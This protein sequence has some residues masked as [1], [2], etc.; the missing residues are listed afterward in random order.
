M[1][2][3]SLAVAAIF[4]M[5]VGLCGAEDVKKAAPVAKAA[6]AVK[7]KSDKGMASAKAAEDTDAEEMESSGVNRENLMPPG[8]TYDTNT[9]MP[10]TVESD[11]NGEIE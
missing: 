1:R 3:L 11:T 8:Q 4:M 10:N 9:G 6:S 5:W 7:A 2:Y